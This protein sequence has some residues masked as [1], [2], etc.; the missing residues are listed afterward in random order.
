MWFHADSNSISI[1]HENIGNLTKLI[2]F[3]MNHNK[4]KSIPASFGNLTEMTF[5]E[6]RHNEIESL[7]VEITNLTNFTNSVLDFGY[8]K[9]DT[10]KLSD[11]IIAW[12]DMYDWDWRKTQDVSVDINLK[13]DNKNHD[14]CIDL[15][16]SSI[17]FYLPTSGMTKLRIYNLKGILI[18]TLIDSYKKNGS[19]K[20]N[21]DINKFGSGIYFI[22]LSSENN[23]I[24]RKTILA[25]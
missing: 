24:I 14:F 19:Y 12:L 8:N 23:C 13:Q 10:N 18:S 3:N 4:L 7:P 20:V 5:L 9:L 2:Y 1:L 15:R 16:N 21:L 6:F 17:L 22:K 25:K 11:T